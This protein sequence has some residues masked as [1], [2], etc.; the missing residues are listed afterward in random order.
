LKDLEQN[1]SE[2]LSDIAQ[3]KAQLFEANSI[4][5]AI[6]DGH[7]D[8]LV[9]K[10]NGQPQVYSLQS[11]DYT[12]RILIEK[13]GE[14]ALSI[15]DSGLILYC[16]DY[17]SKMVGMQA[18]EI[19]GTYFNTYVDD[20][21]EFL[22][23][24]KTL[25]SGISKGEILL[26]TGEGKLHVYVSLTDL[27]PNVEAIGVVITDLSE[28]RKH[29]QALLKYQKKLELKVNELNL[30]NTNLEQF[31]HVVSHDIKE[32]LRK[33]LT[34][35]SHLTDTSATAFTTSELKNLNIVNTAAQRLNS[36]VDDLVKYAFSATKDETEEVDLNKIVKDVLDD[37]EIVIT[38]NKAQ[39]EFGTL[40]KIQASKVQMR[41]LFANLISNAIKY[42]KKNIPAQ[43]KVTASV[44]DNQNLVNE[45]EK[46]HIIRIRDHGIGMDKMHLNKIFTIFQRL[47]LRTEYSGNGIGLAICKKIME[48]HQG[49]IDVESEL[50]QGSTFC[51]YFPIN[52]T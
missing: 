50:G 49:K 46:C 15:S 28:K 51:L 22:K 19:V 27:H 4:I 18:S 20:P 8:A 3:L 42:S 35:T 12:Y 38:E 2:L 25:N 52:R 24:K 48:N 37:L 30:T 6:R 47:H 44:V 5:E 16:N 31:I 40:P 34:Y 41:Q 36:L 39:I 26:N 17:F 33:I 13:F 9:L 10:N 45:A 23:L 11:A 1:T 14:G 43:I 29:E 32:P 7:V 21:A